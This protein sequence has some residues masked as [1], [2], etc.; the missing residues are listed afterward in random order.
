MGVLVEQRRFKRI[1]IAFALSI[2]V[3]SGDRT[4]EAESLGI[5]NISFSGVYFKTNG[6]KKLKPDDILS[7][8]ITIPTKVA[9]DFPFSRIIGRA[10]VVR[11]EESPPG[12]PELNAERAIALEFGPEAVRLK[13]TV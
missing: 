6:L 12:E 1:E 11:V 7:L 13:A 8:D 4:E 10:R 2:S 3:L 5:S 9:V